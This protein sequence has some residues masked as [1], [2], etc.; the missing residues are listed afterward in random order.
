MKLFTVT[1]VLTLPSFVSFAWW[2]SRGAEVQES[3]SAVPVVEEVRQ[4]DALENRAAL[5]EAKAELIALERVAER[6]RE[7]AEK[8][9]EV[10]FEQDARDYEAS[11]MELEGAIG[12]LR[13]TV[14]RLD[15]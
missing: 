3:V 5:V 6:K 12:E 14:A 2:V 4:Y 13:E 9:R 11:L 10:G 7:W 1:A 15:G 8:S